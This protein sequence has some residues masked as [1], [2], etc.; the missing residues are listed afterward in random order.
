MTRENETQA[1]SESSDLL[2]AGKKPRIKW[3]HPSWDMYLI[4]DS[5]FT[6]ADL[7]RNDFLSEGDNPLLVTAEGVWMTDSEVED[8]G[9]WDG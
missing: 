3:M 4:T 2:G 8:L 1:G 7:V 5:N 6:V 9:E